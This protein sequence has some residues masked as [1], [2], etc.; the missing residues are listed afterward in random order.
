MKIINHDKKCKKKNDKENNLS[1]FR[2]EGH[3]RKRYIK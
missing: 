3:M 2:T 1:R